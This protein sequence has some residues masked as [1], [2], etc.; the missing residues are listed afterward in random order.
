MLAYI[1]QNYNIIWRHPDAVE[2][3]WTTFLLG[4][5]HRSS[6][7][8]EEHQ[9]YVRALQR[10]NGTFVSTFATP[11]SVLLVEGEDYLQKT[12][13]PNYIIEEQL[14]ATPHISSDRMIGWDMKDY[15]HLVVCKTF[16]YNTVLSI[17]EY[18]F[19]C[20]SRNLGSYNWEKELLDTGRK[21]FIEYHR[22]YCQ[23]H[24]MKPL[25]EVLVE[26]A[27]EMDNFVKTK[28]KP[29]EE[30]RSLSKSGVNRRERMRALQDKARLLFEKI[31]EF[32][33]LTLFHNKYFPMRTHAMITTLSN[34]RSYVRCNKGKVFLIAGAFHLEEDPNEPEQSKKFCSLKPFYD[35]LKDR[36]DIVILQPKCMQEE[37]L[38]DDAQL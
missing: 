37:V 14:I 5:V 15:W 21:S 32:N 34:I 26:V 12:S 20:L 4:E 16:A 10:V 17:L 24:K 25:E 3:D 27:H 22:D 28:I 9:N 35:F 1:N 2:S 19:T 13:V 6:G 8:G 23:E 18:Y 38:Q 11:D 36:K 30:I 7:L 29:L 33:D 31:K